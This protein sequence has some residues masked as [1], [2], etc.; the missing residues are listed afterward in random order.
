MYPIRLT[1]A[2]PLGHLHFESPGCGVPAQSHHTAIFSLQPVDPLGQQLLFIEKIQ[3]VQI[4]QSQFQIARSF[5]PLPSETYE[6]GCGALR[7][8]A[9]RLEVFIKRVAKEKI[10]RGTRGTGKMEY[11]VPVVSSCPEISPT[12][13]PNPKLTEKKTT[14]PRHSHE[15]SSEAIAVS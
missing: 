15:H 3:S 12:V 4:K 5:T 14:H 1:N 7:F 8:M 10:W 2:H 13:P 9:S 11:T 6:E